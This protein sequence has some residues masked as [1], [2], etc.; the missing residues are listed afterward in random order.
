MLMLAGG[1]LTL[2]SLVLH[3]DINMSESMSMEITWFRVGWFLIISPLFYD[4][5]VFIVS[6]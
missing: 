6:L 4:C 1:I 2:L 3:P 5:T